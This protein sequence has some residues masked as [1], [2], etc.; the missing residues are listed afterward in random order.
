MQ[1]LELTYQTLATTRNEAAVDA[2]IAALDDPNAANRRRALGALLSRTEPRSS[3]Q[4][5]ENWSKLNADD[6]RVL[7]PRKSWLAVAIDKALHGKG[8]TV[9][10]AITAATGLELTAALPQL[11]LLAESSASRDIQQRASDAVIS[12]VQSLGRAARADRDQPTVRG[13]ALARLADSVRRFSMHRNEQLVDAFLLVSTWG[14]AELRQMISENGPQMELICKRLQATELPGVID[15][16]S[17][18]IRRKNI[19]QRIGGIIQSRTD[20]PFREA[21]LRKITSEPTATVLNN[22]RDIGIPKSCL[23]GEEILTDIAPDYRAP[24][25]HLYV[26]GNRDVT[27]TLHL[28]AAAVE[29]GSGCEI[30]AAMCLS[31]CEVPDI[32]VWMRAAIPVADGDEAAIAADDNARL[33]Q[34]L[35][36]LL[37]HPDAG[38]SKGVRRVLGPLHAEQMLP[39]FDSLRPRSR[40]RL[41]RVVMMVDPDAIQRVRDALRH[42]VLGNR[43]EAIAMADALAV[44]DLLSDSFTHIAHEDHQE[45]RVR[46]AQVM[47]DASGDA[48]LRLLREMTE[49]PE[50]IVRD[51]ALQSLEQR[52][53]T[54]TR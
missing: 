13:P 36:N 46:A 26:A 21:L 39:R 41:G 17:G 54:K 15:L 16:L 30:A 44:V 3:Q 33:L 37:D 8:E 42:P 52:Q 43:L 29:S 32:D 5:L 38:L 14:D 19:P 7:R 50:C 24:M 27:E 22:I 25:L 28:I 18:F 1:G 40:R 12:I 6:L 47:S 45:A 51:A 49:L 23:G 10:T 9:L 11:T 34:R 48:T 2:L 20:E 53:T 35:I 4:V 31:R